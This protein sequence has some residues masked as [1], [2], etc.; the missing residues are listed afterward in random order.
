MLNTIMAVPSNEKAP[1]KSYRNEHFPHYSDYLHAYARTGGCKSFLDA[2][3]ELTK[4]NQTNQ[5]NQTKTK[6]TKLNCWEYSDQRLNSCVDP[7]AVVWLS[8]CVQQPTP[9][10]AILTPVIETLRQPP[11]NQSH[12]GP[13]PILPTRGLFVFRLM[14]E[15]NQTSYVA[16]SWPKMTYT[17]GPEVRKLPVFEIPERAWKRRIRVLEYHTE[18][19][20]AP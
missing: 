10:I 19:L 7:L 8:D 14:A 2:S 15:R 17:G 18:H 11:W 4:P 9:N 5:T 12:P 20:V 16:C 3:A 1:L 6:Q 13:S